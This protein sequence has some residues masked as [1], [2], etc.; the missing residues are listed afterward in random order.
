MFHR[1]KKLFLI[2]IKT[3]NLIFLKNGIFY[4]LYVKFNYKDDLLWKILNIKSINGY[5]KFYKDS[6][7]GQYYVLP[8]TDLYE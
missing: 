4:E 7:T 2:C 8:V 1:I 3:S 6:R 5:A